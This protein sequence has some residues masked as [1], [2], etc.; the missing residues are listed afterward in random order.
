MKRLFLMGATAGA[1]LLGLPAA[2]ACTG[3]ANVTADAASLSGPTQSTDLSAAKKKKRV[4]RSSR[5]GGGGS[6]AGTGG[7]AAGEGGSGSSSER[8]Q[9][10]PR[11]SP[12]VPAT[13]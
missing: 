7:G 2:Q 5:K 8:Q 13:R 12:T 6:K 9:G 11:G 1:L 4:M 10:T 3:K